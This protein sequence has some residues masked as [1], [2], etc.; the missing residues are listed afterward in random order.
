M[1]GRSFLP[2]F[3][4]T[5]SL[6]GADTSAQRGV[7]QHRLD[8][9]QTNFRILAVVP[10][11]GSGTKTDPIRPAYAP[12]PPAQGAKRDPNGIIGFT[13]QISDDKKHALVEFVARNRAA[14]A[15]LLADTR[16]DVKVFE[17]GKDKKANIENE[18]RKYKKDLN[19]DA[20]I[21]RLP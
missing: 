15:Q 12:A 5:C 13:F 2:F 7:V 6:F 11:I 3:L 4:V 1:I 20:M 19:L 21:V 10:L 18:L 16:S 8:A 14:F 9:G 17:R